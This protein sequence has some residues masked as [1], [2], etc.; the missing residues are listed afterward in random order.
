MPSY[1]ENMH[2]EN[3]LSN[4]VYIKFA[5]QLPIILILRYVNNL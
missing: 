1:S 2:Y 5:L 4:T 3:K